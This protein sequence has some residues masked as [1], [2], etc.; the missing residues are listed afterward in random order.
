MMI[1]RDLFDKMDL[2]FPGQS[3]VYRSEFDGY[4]VRYAVSFPA[5]TPKAPRLS[6]EFI[7]PK[8]APVRVLIA[9]KS[10]QIVIDNLYYPDGSPD[11]SSEN[12]F[13]NTDELSQPLRKIVEKAFKELFGW[14]LKE[15]NIETRKP[16]K[17]D[18]L[19][20]L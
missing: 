19:K 4:V 5:I 7:S 12:C 16:T 20:R 18:F 17:E 9:E 11:G 3:N 13:Y 6:L 1:P 8:G 10:F 2:L 14:M 15:L